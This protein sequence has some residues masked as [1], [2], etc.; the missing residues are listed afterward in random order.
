MRI[1]KRGLVCAVAL[2]LSVAAVAFVAV[3]GMW[4]AALFGALAGLA[5]LSELIKEASGQ[6]RIL[7]FDFRPTRAQQVTVGIIFSLGYTV[8]RVTQDGWWIAAV[9]GPIILALSTWVAWLVRTEGWSA[10]E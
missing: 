2:L 5:I 10:R 7:P 9:G 4:L 8:W 3:L 6:D 1:T